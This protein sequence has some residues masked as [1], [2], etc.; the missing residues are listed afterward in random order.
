M[1]EAR[2]PRIRGATSRVTTI[3]IAVNQ[4]RYPVDHF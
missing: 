1:H 2:K 4:L 3:V